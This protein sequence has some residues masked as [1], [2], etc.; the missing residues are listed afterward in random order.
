MADEAVAAD[1]T[2]VCAAYNEPM[3]SA[4]WTR[5]VFAAARQRGLV[6]AL[7]SDGHSTPEAIRYLR[8]VTDVLRIDLKAHDE[9]SYRKLGGRLYDGY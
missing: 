3:V 6:T 4:E 2:V 9:A 8:G 5:S 1:C 7:I